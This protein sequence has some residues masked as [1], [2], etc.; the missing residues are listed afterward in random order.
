M[1]DASSPKPVR[2]RPMA[3]IYMLELRE[4]NRIPIVDRDIAMIKDKCLPK[5]SFK[6]DIVR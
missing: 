6:M 2:K 3:A 1:R 5:L 4:M